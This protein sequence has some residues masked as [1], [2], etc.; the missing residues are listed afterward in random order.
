MIPFE[1]G[2]KSRCARER[3]WTGRKRHYV[4]RMCKQDFIH[5]SAYPLPDG[6]RICYECR[7]TPEGLAKF[8]QGFID[9]H[10]K[11]EKQGLIP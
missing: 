6:S 4:C 1:V 8:D 5:D 10:E 7:I 2:S 3:G 11:D 9:Q